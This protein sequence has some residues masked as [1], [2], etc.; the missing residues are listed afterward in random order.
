MQRSILLVVLLALPLLSSAAA[1]YKWVDAQGVT[2]FSDQPFPGA[3]KVTVEAAQTYA[4]PQ[5]PAAPSTAR[6]P[7]TAPAKPYNLCEIAIPTNDQVYFAVQ[8][9]GARLRVQPQLRADDRVVVV[10]DGK[11]MPNISAAGGEFTL[12]PT[13]RGTH[14]VGAVVEDAHG[15]KQCEA[16]SVTFHVRQ[17]SIYGPNK[18]ATPHR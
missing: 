3:Q 14:T 17:P 7:A 18:P 10:Y 12:T 15:A 1:V 4:A 16:P 8:S 6:A 13:Y 9:V 2:H 11:R 5:P